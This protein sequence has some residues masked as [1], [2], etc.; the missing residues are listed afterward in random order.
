MGFDPTRKFTAR[1]GDYALIAV[2]VI[3]AALLVVWALIA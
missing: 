2:V 1:R 3:S